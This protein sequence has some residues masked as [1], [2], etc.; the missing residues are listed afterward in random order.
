LARNKNVK[1]VFANLDKIRIDESFWGNPQKPVPVLDII[2]ITY[3]EV[4]SDKIEV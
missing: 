3:F 2:R 4:F 1:K